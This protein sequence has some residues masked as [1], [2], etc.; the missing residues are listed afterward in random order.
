MF[1]SVPQ[2]YD[3][4][5]MK[6]IIHDW[7]DDACVKILRGCRAGVSIAVAVLTCRIT[8]LKATPCYCDR[9]QRASSMTA[10]PEEWH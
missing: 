2:G 6:H 10:R 9:W 1:A 7:P 8:V 5:I 3:A 4:Y